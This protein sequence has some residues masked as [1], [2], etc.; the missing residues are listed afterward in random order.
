MTKNEPDVAKQLAVAD[1]FDPVAWKQR[2][3]AIPWDQGDIT[4]G[5]AAFAKASCAACHD[6]GRA[7]GPSLLG[8]GKRF[9]RDDLLTTILQPGKDVSPRYRPTRVTTVDDQVFIG[10]VVYEA[11]DGVILQ[12]D[13]DTTVRVAGDK[14]ASKKSVDASLMPAGLLDKLTDAE[15]A[16]LFAYLKSL[17]EPKR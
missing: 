13:A 12:T 6:T 17:D 4:R 11:T 1:G 3:V 7:I 14:I 16:D 8:I 10:M 2:E 15:V 9:G 5:R